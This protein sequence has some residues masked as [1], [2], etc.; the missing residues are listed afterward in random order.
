MRRIAAKKISKEPV[1]RILVLFLLGALG[2]I[3]FGVGMLW[4]EQTGTLVNEEYLKALLEEEVNRGDLFFYTVWEHLKELVFF[5]L[6]ALTWLNLP[7][8]TLHLLKQGF[9]FGFLAE[10]FLHA[11]QLQGSVLLMAYYV[12]Q[13]LVQIPL[14]IY[15]Y[16][17]AFRIRE[18]RRKRQ[19]YLEKEQ[20]VLMNESPS[21]HKINM[22]HLNGKSVMLIIAVCLI[23]AALEVWAGTWIIKRAVGWIFGSV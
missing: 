3:L 1:V 8:S 2:G 5:F 7:Y 10:A 19:N 16:Q 15:C 13:C 20:D 12:P 22:L 23:C 6:M 17:L 14:W 11:Y 21:L 9:Y 4:L 18:E